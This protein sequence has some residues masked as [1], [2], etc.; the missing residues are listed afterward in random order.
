MTKSSPDC[1]GT[2]QN[3]TKSLNN[4]IL[5]GIKYFANNRNAIL[6]WCLNRAEQAKN[7][8]KMKEK[9]GL[10]SHAKEYKPLRLSQIRKSEK[11]VESIMN[12]LETD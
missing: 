9:D 5:G 7:T 10:K 8:G 6:K 11:H 3:T 4:F 1:I 12:I 2:K